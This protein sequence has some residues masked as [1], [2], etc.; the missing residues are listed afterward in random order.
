M[1]R[2]QNFF[3]KKHFSVQFIKNVVYKSSERCSQ[4]RCSSKNIPCNFHQICKCSVRCEKVQRFLRK[5]KEKGILTEDQHETMYPSSSQFLRLYDNS[6]THKL[7]SESDK[8][9]FVL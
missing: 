2:F 9:T 7:K 6:K 5:L 3:L 4:K 8:L 1:G